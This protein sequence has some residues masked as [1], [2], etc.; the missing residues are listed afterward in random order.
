MGVD[1]TKVRTA[2]FP[3]FGWG[4]FP[5]AFYSQELGSITYPQDGQ[6]PTKLVQ[7]NIGGIFVP[8]GA[9]AS[10]EDHSF[11]L[12]TDFGYFVEWVDFTIYIQLPHPPGDKLCVLRS[13]VEDQ[14]LFCHAQS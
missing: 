3:G 4:D 2:V 7:V 1:I 10:R 11:D 14:Y 13:K 9:G 12:G 8:D 6:P 5:A